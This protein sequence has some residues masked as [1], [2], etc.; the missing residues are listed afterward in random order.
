MKYTWKILSYVFPLCLEWIY[1]IYACRDDIPRIPNYI[2]QQV[3]LYH[4]P[5]DAFER[6]ISMGA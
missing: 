5:K 1:V 6:D 3:L 2:G 4:N